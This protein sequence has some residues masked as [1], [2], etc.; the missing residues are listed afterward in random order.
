MLFSR[1]SILSGVGYDWW[2]DVEAMSTF[3]ETCGGVVLFCGGSLEKIAAQ[4]PAE[5]STS[6]TTTTHNF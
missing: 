4:I 3:V 6:T 2:L 5:Q 1:L